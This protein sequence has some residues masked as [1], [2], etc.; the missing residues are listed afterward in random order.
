[1]HEALEGN[2]PDYEV[3]IVDDASTDRTP[4]LADDLARRDPRVRVV[5]N[6]TNRKL[7]GAL[8]AGYAAFGRV[9][10]GMDVVRAIFAAPTDPDKGDGF[11]KGQMLAE[12]V[13]IVVVRRAE[14]A[15]Q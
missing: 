6:P 7:G 13:K 3:V 9:V 1:M 12:P 14:Q 4:A 8:R 11:M 2:V 10:E 5:H 15:A